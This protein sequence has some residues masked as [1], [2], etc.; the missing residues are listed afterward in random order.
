M[1]LP[2][3]RVR[4]AA[5]SD[6][7]HRRTLTELVVLRTLLLLLLTLA[8]LLGHIQHPDFLSRITGL[9]ALFGLMLL[10]SLLTWLRLRLPHGVDAD[11]IFL[12]LLADLLLLTLLFRLSGGHSNPFVTY[13]LVPL[14][15]AAS[16]LPWRQTLTLL[17]LVLVAYG[18]LLWQ[19]QSPD[20]VPWPW[21]SYTGHLTGMALNF[22]ISAWLMVFFLARMSRRLRRQERRLAEAQR[23][24]LQRDQ[25]VAMGT[26]AAG[27]V[28]DLATPL[29][30]M[31]LLL[32]ELDEQPDDASVRLTLQ[33]QLQRCRDI[34]SGLREQAR[35]PDTLPTRAL[36]EHLHTCQQTV[37]ML[38]PGCQVRCL[39]GVDDAQLVQLPWRLQQV[40]HNGLKNAAEA[41]A[42]LA[43][44]EAWRADDQLH[45]RIRDDGPGFPP[46]LL[47]QVG[48]PL[49]SSKPDGLGLGLFLSSVTVSE[50]GGRLMLRNLP[51]G[52]AELAL[53]VPWSVVNPEKR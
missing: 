45:C 27:A 31:T 49:D 20:G 14:A 16:A 32:E 1:T 19:A 35:H 23:Q 24:Q 43:T 48:M 15:M 36:A 26:L 38:V 40:L 4:H 6:D 30:S 50:L 37:Q 13:Y 47:A 3:L 41:A 51:E 33:Q 52:G 7:G 28:H 34:L 11:E 5:P 21:H 42:S 18:S 53:Y 17:V 9:P 8:T 44:L 12:Q 22:L 29:A 25:A 10:V 39:A 46:V 2:D